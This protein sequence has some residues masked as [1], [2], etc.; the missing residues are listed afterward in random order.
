ME[1]CKTCAF[2]C[3]NKTVDFCNNGDGTCYG[4]ESLATF[5]NERW[6]NYIYCGEPYYPNKVG[7]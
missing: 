3:D 6:N 4:Y 1:I 2:D 5:N 7:N